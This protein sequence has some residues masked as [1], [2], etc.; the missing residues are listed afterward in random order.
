M[1]IST[2][3]NVLFLFLFLFF[4]FFF[5]FHE[6][7]FGNTGRSRG[8]F[9][10]FL[11]P[12]WYRLSGIYRASYK[13]SDVYIIVLQRQAHL[14]TVPPKKFCMLLRCSSSGSI[15]STSTCIKMYVSPFVAFTQDIT[16]IYIR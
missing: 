14:I 7:I 11:F 6:F 12:N 4:Y 16:Y 2:N 3:S 9:R 5:F 10:I 8:K 1:P 15:V 13:N